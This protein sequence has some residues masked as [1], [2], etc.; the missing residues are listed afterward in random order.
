MEFNI[1]LNRIIDIKDFVDITYR[2][3]YKQK[4]AQDTFVVDA[5]SIMGVLSLDWTQ[6][7]KYVC[8]A[9]DDELMHMLARFRAED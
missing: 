4:V 8:D 3:P 7:A 2:F 6:P 1:I 9:Y 5:K